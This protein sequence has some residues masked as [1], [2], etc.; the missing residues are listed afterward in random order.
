ML[1]KDFLLK[2]IEDFFQKLNQ[3]MQKEHHLMPSNEMETAYDEFMKTHFQ[4]GIREIHFLDTE[5]YKDILFNE[6]HR[7]WIQLFF[8]KIAYHFR[9]K[10]PQFAQK[11]VDLVQKIREYPYKSIALIKD[12]T[13]KE[14]EKL[15]ER[16]T[17]EE[18]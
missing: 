1:K 16:W 6:S 11:Y 7:G 12:T 18:H 9:E 3:L 13:E 2:Y 14:V 17:A 4:I 8:L 15:L 5:Q 10:E